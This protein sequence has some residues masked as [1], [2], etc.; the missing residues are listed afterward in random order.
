M[1]PKGITAFEVT[2]VVLQQILEQRR[3][4]PICPVL[5]HRPVDLLWHCD[6]TACAK[7]E[8]DAQ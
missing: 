5:V 3:T 6:Q 8:G 1:G 7:Y 2:P 4:R